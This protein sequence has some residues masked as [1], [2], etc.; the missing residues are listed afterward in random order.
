MVVFRL[1]RDAELEV[2]PEGVHDFRKAM[3]SEIRR[4]RRSDAVRLEATAGRGDAIVERIA[5][6]V[7]LGPLEIYRLPGPIDLRAIAGLA[8]TAGLDAQRY[9]AFTPD[10]AI[11][12]MEGSFWDTVAAGDAL[13]SHPYDSFEPVERMVREAAD[14]PAVLAIKMTLY[15]PGAE[16]AIVDSLVRAAER[17]KQVT[18]IVELLARFDEEKNIEWSHRLERAGAH[19]IYGV[20]GLK[21]H[22]K[23][24]LVVRREPSG[25]RRY[26]HLGT[27]N[28]NARTARLYTDLS[29]FTADE[30][31]GVDA[32]SF[33]NVLT[34]YSDPP[35]MR[36]FL[37]APLAIRSR[38][39]EL[40]AR[41]ADHARRGVPAE[42]AIKVNSLSDPGAIAAL[43]EA[44]RA[45]VEV[46]LVVRGICCLRPGVPGGSDRIQV[47]SIVDRYLE[48]S[49][50]YYFRN[51][52]HE[53]VYLASA[54]LMPRN[55]DRR[56][57]LMFPVLAAPLKDRLR[58]MLRQYLKD[59]T[60]AWQLQSDG[61]YRPRTPAPSEPP[62]RV[63]EHFM[64]EASASA[65]AP[66]ASFRPRART[67]S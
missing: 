3:E 16:S 41:E 42:I 33:F 27:G 55:L 37:M 10:P 67:S 26:V 38:F 48:H 12:L 57:E 17:D 52:G 8:T 11:G 30:D 6:K 18:V 61:T 35:Q 51:A 5:R 65:T 47:I 28:Y 66:I 32:S 15:R 24:A 53:E 64:E 60:R 39:L 56:V 19:V 49:R 14:D 31:F 25:I 44:S 1:T 62:F 45:G 54:D 9:P 20:A 36:R 13:L 34:G 21:T 50:I 4:R 58:N 43:Y 59:N 2:D 40:V 63:Q 29:L 7:G 22:A 46:R 23:I